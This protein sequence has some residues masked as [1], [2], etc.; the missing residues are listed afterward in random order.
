VGFCRRKD[1]CKLR[2]RFATH[3]RL[4]VSI[5]FKV[6]VLNMSIDLI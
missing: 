5:C 3:R 4:M 2:S 1:Y 6:T